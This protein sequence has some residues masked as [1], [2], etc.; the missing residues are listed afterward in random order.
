MQVVD[1]CSDDCNCVGIFLFDYNVKAYKY[2][3]CDYNSLVY[4]KCLIHAAIARLSI[5]V[6]MYYWYIMILRTYSI[7]APVSRLGSTIIAIFMTPAR[8]LFRETRG[9]NRFF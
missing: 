3:K 1:E 9:A 2:F 4:Q 6:V 5:T 7:C 8:P